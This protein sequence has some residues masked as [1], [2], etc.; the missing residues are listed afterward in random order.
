MYHSTND[1]ARVRRF[2]RWAS[3]CFHIYLWESHEPMKG[4]A[5]EMSTDVSELVKPKGG[6]KRVDSLE[7]Q[8]AA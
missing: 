8:A 3:D 6:W 1:L 5:K 7:L 2:G 4:V